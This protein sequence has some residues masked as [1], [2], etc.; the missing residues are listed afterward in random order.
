MENYKPCRLINSY[1]INEDS[2]TVLTFDSMIKLKDAS[3]IMW[4]NADGKHTISDIIDILKKVYATATY[5]E[6]YNGVIQLLHQLQ[7]KGIII[8]NWDP[9]LKDELPQEV[10]IV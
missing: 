6:L 1:R 4:L 5:E 8:S 2:V 7:K 10:K 9:I 3:M